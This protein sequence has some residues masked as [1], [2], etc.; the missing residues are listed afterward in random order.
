MESQGK[1]LL[2]ENLGN[3]VQLVKR[4]ELSIEY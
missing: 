1:I 4:N 3:H 2:L